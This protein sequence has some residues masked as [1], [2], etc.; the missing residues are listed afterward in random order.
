M[1]FAS[2]LTR[3]PLRAAMQCNH[4]LLLLR[5][6]EYS[7]SDLAK[8]LVVMDYH[9]RYVCNSNILG[10][11]KILLHSFLLFLFYLSIPS[12]VVRWPWQVLYYK[13]AVSLLGDRLV[14][15]TVTTKRHGGKQF[16]NTGQ[17]EYNPRDYLSITLQPFVGPWP[18]FSCLKWDWIPVFEQ[19]KTVH[20]LDREATVIG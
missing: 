18:L 5:V 19:A 14:H 1:N 3:T 4:S 13:V 11:Y 16:Q 7:A 20:A 6:Q 2:N 8:I 10:V 9:P 17:R 12:V 15:R